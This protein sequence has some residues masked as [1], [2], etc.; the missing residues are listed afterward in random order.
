MLLATDDVLGVFLERLLAP[1]QLAP[2]WF[3]LVLVAAAAIT[4]L[5]G[6]TSKKWVAHIFDRRLGTFRNQLNEESQ[7]RLAALRSTLDEES[8]ARLTLRRRALK[9]VDGNKSEAA[10]LL[11]INITTVYRKMEKYRIVD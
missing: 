5:A 3:G 11:G 10:K 8:R 4:Y 9:Q 1:V 2:L 7:E 6:L